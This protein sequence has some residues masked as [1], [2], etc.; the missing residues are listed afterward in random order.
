M[1]P[2]SCIGKNLAYLELRM[3]LARMILAKLIWSFELELG[4]GCWEWV[5]GMKVFSLFEKPS[6]MMRLTP[7]ER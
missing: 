1:G 6:L 2:R 3:I 4:D 7:V 5:M